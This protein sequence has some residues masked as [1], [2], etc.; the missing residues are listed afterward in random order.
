MRIGIVGPFDPSSIADYLEENEVPSINGMATAVNTLV[1]EFL[2]QGYHLVIFTLSILQSKR[3]RVLRGKNVEIHLIPSG[4]CPRLLGSH[5]MLLGQFYLPRRIAKEIEPEIDKLEVL[6]AHWTYEYAKAAS[7]LSS[8]IKVFDTVRDWC[9]YQLTVQKDFTSKLTWMLKNITFKQ[10]MADERITF[11]ANSGYTY[12]MIKGAYPGKD[13]PVI[14]NPIDKSWLLEEKK[15]QIRHEIISIA[16]GL[17]SPRKNIIKLLE[18]FSYYRKENPKAVLHLVGRYNEN[19][20]EYIQWKESKLLEGVIFH[21]VLPREELS[22]LLDK[23]SCL[24]HPSLEETFGNILL[25]AMARGVPCIGG[26]S[27]GAV[28]E[29]LGYGKYG[30]ICDIRSSESIFNAM[31]EINDSE[32]SVKI[33]RAATEMLKQT[34]TSDVVIKKHVELFQTNNKKK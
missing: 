14:P 29:V 32:K 27:S 31:N 33:Q 1:R 28:P 25:E 2:L 7:C 9:P 12:K 5:Q 8:R 17:T 30:V 23:M 13:V 20:S 21:G 6:H 34:Y 18:A 26:D 4:L 11:I 15:N 16:S 10:V 3:T 24:V 19:D 22:A